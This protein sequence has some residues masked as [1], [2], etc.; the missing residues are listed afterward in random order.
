[1]IHIMANEIIT[2]F[3]REMTDFGLA[4]AV[5]FACQALVIATVG[6]EEGQMCIRDSLCRTVSI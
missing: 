3:C 4:P 6:I 5:A 1:M 2:G